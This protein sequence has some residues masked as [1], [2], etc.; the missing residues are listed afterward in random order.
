MNIAK[1]ETDRVKIYELK[2]GKLKLNLPVGGQTAGAAMVQGDSVVVPLRDGDKIR[3]K[4]YDV[5]TGNLK[6]NIP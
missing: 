5:K 4:I 2:T 3:M 1:T 6:L